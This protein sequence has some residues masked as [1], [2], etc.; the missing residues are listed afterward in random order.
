MYAD[1]IVYIGKDNSIVL[2]LMK[3]NVAITHTDITRCQALV[4]ATLLDSNSTPALFNL[5]QID[6]IT[7]KFGQAGL[8]AGRY[9]VTLTVFD[10]VNTNGIV[11]GE[12]PVVVV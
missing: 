2:S 10:A 3:D 7:L 12:F 9:P 4:G 11:W 6:R 5:T 1:E 8:V